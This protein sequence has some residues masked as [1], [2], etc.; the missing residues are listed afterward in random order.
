MMKRWQYV[1]FA[2]LF[3]FV[4]FFV[5][6][7][8]FVSQTQNLC[9]LLMWGFED[10]NCRR[11]GEGG[12][13]GE[14]G[15]LDFLKSRIVFLPFTMFSLYSHFSI[16]LNLTLGGA[17]LCWHKFYS[18]DHISMII[19]LIFARGM[20]I[21]T[22]AYAVV[23]SWIWSQNVLKILF[24]VPETAVKWRSSDGVWVLLCEGFVTGY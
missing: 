4:C 16:G 13:G 18:T 12:G 11:G 14:G 21:F 17:C 20:E 24:I 9:Q 2:A 5:S 22:T 8:A 19:Y 6:N 10:G 23:G 15:R 7:K 1:Y 3:F